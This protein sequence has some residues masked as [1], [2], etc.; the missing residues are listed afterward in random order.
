M[1]DMYDNIEQILKDYVPKSDL[2]KI[3]KWIEADQ[4]TMGGG[5]PYQQRLCVAD[6]LFKLKEKTSGGGVMENK[7]VRLKL[8]DKTGAG[9][10]IH[11]FHTQIEDCV[12]FSM[13]KGYQIIA[14]EPWVQF[15]SSQRKEMLAEVFQQMVD[16]W[17][18]KYAK[19]F[20]QVGWS[21]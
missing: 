17:N 6:V 10:Q 20:E 16:L 13:K 14:S 18:D 1:G 12:E 2:R 7:I 15:G 9:L 3:V 5:L 19:D 11:G 21:E 8:V 4:A